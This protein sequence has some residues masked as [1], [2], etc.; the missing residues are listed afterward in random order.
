VPC[1]GRTRRSGSSG[2]VRRPVGHGPR[3]ELR[4][5]VLRF[6][7]LDP[8]IGA[9]GDRESRRES[10]HLAQLAEHRASGELRAGN[11]LARRIDGRE[12]DVVC[13]RHLVEFDHRVAFEIIREW[14][15][16]L[17]DVLFGEFVLI[18]LVPVPLRP[19]GSGKGLCLE[20]LRH[21]P[22][23]RRTGDTPAQTE[24]HPAVLAL[25]DFAR[26]TQSSAQPPAHAPAVPRVVP[27]RTHIGN[28]HG[29]L[30]RHVDYLGLARGQPTER[31]DR[32]FRADVRIGRRLAAAQR[33]AVREARG[34][35]VAAGGHRAQIRGVPIRSRT[36][37]AERRDANPDG[38]RRLLW[39]Q[40]Q[41]A[42]PTG[43]VEHDIG[44]GQQCVEPRVVRIT[45]DAGLACVPREE[46]QR[47]LGVPP[48]A[49]ER[50]DPSQRIATLRLQLD[51]FGAEIGQQTARDLTGLRRCIDYANSLHQGLTHGSLL[52][53]AKKRRFVT[54]VLDGPD[55]DTV[56]FVSF[57]FSFSQCLSTRPQRPESTPDDAR[58]D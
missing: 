9:P 7:R 56:N 37:Q 39:S 11:H 33:S 54:I 24:A 2:C 17:Q 27:H 51:D 21:F 38:L 3:I 40:L 22:I 12:H 50:A 23:R 18:E 30:N 1:P 19:G 41:S 29:L 45:H 26:R 36:R 20:D 15:F 8:A 25:P 4:S 49:H 48:I 28:Q 13:G 16:D 55:A 58:K 14:R 57:T 5:R 10:L 32:S 34:V 43:R 53:A 52:R 31:C 42:R 47:G 44:A 35:H 46:P 6:D